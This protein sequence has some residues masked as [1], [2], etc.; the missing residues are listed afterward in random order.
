LIFERS[1]SV[2]EGLSE[3]VFLASHGRLQSCDAS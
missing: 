2:V 1:L 3:T